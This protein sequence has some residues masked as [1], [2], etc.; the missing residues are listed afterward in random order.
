MANTNDGKSTRRRSGRPAAVAWALAVATGLVM[1]SFQACSAAAGTGLV[2]GVVTRGM[3]PPVLL[4]G[5]QPPPPLPV[6]AVVVRATPVDARL[7]AASART[8]ATGRY[9]LVLQPGAYRLDLD[10][11]PGGGFHKPARDPVLVKAHE[12]I[13]HDFRI[14]SGMR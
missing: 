12:E 3:G 14:D 1:G 6:A 2:T 13:R 8:D 7:P 10:E 9:R 4:P 5:E 11:I